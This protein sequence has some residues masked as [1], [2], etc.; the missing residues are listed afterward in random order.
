[1]SLTSPGIVE[2][3]EI[4]VRGEELAVSRGEPGAPVVREGLVVVDPTGKNTDS[5]T[6]S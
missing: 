2:G 3:I 4:E 5:R 6:C 1:M